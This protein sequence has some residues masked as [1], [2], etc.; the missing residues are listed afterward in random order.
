MTLYELPD[1]EQTIA[2]LVLDLLRAP[3]LHSEL[4][5]TDA[6]DARGEV[7]ADSVRLSYHYVRALLAYGFT[8]EQEELADAAAWFSTPF[9]QRARMDTVE[10]NRLE[11][12]LNLR[13]TDDQVTPRMSQLLR[14]RTFDGYFDLGGSPDFDTLWTL[15]VMTLA[16]EVGVLN[17]L[18]TADDLKDWSAR[19]IR[20]NHRDKD[21]ALALRL[22]YSLVGKFSAQQKRSLLT[23]I[24]SAKTHHGMWGLT[25]DT[26]W[27]AE[28]L[29]KHE[30]T[31]GEVADHRSRI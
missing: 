28:H 21:M 1:F 16:K 23:L 14:Q 13:P 2:D 22:R 5:L 26:A 9:D 15:K 18:M 4:I 12:L 7:P 17:G 11:A 31:P 6:Q 8:A 3:R 24:N 25:M 10:M 27:L 19:V 20:N 30:L 29:R